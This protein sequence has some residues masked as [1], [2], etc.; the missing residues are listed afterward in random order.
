[1][2][3]KDVVLTLVIDVDVGALDVSKTCFAMLVLALFRRF[4]G[5]GTA[6]TY[7]R[8]FA[9]TSGRRRG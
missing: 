4:N 2:L 6:M 9:A 5:L 8:A 7:L 3:L 1:M